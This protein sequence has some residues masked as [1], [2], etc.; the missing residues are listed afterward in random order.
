[1]RGPPW[2]RQRGAGG[3]APRSS[4]RTPSAPPGSMA[5]TVTGDGSPAWDGAATSRARR[6]APAGAAAR[7]G[8]YLPVVAP[9]CARR[10]GACLQRQ[11][12][13]GGRRAGERTRARRLVLLTD[14]DGVRAADG[15]RIDRPDVRG[16]RTPDRRRDD[17]G[18]DGARRCAPL[19]SCARAGRTEAVIA[20]GAAAGALSRALDDPVERDAIASL[21]WIGSSVGER[22]RSSSP[23][24]ARPSGP[25]CRFSA[26]SS[27][28][29]FGPSSTRRFDL[30]AAVRREAVHHERV[31][32]DRDQLLGDGVRREDG[33]PLRPLGLLAHARPDVRV[34][35]VGAEHAG[36]RVVATARP[37]R[38]T[39]AARC[40]GDRH[41]RRVRLV[42]GGRDR[43]HVHPQRRGRDQQRGTDVVAVA[44]EDDGLAA[45]A[46]RGARGA[47][48]R[49]PMPERVLAIRQRVHDGDRARRRPS[50]RASRGCGRARRWR[51]RSAPG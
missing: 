17:R 6:S 7:G 8:G 35:R 5:A 37:S 2:R 36:F 13:R 44:D 30:L 1:M 9:V 47:S 24:R 4:A 14:S 29:L 23:A 28:T 45:R 50:P 21:S 42:P 12:R 11:R 43:S 49:R 41:D 32:R 19:L 27:T 10:G 46:H 20:D 38:P 48:A 33:Q 18:R 15:A 34:D 39:R 25:T 40:L 51:R 31:G 3:D 16:S 22:L 26:W